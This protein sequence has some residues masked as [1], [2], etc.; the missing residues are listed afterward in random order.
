M[1]L[2][3]PLRDVTG[4]QAVDRALALLSVVGRYAE[5]GVSLTEIVAKTDLNKPTARRLLLALMRAGLVE[6]DEQTR[7]YFLGEETFVLGSLA[8][9]RYGLLQMAMDGLVRLSRKT[10]D[11]SFLSVRRGTYSLCLYREEGTFPVRTHALQAGFEH[12]LGV[13]AGSLAMLAALPDDEVEAILQANHEVLV[14]RYPMLPASRIRQDVAQT[15]STGFALNP[16]LIYANSWGVGVAISSAAGQ[17]VGALSVA[18]ID[19]RLQPARQTEI[20]GY[21]AEEVRKL[22]VRLAQVPSALGNSNK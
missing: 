21:L 2:A 16:G 9:R 22:E 20:A 7:L 18:A 13:G 6:Q 14:Q 15:R 17:P 12:P 4:S 11:S 5:R 19:S 8:S 10:E 1:D 3:Q